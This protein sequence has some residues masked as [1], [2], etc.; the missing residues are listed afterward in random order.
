[1]STCNECEKK[2]LCCKCSKLLCQQNGSH[3]TSERN[4]TPGRPCSIMGHYKLVDDKVCCAD[5]YNQ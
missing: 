4:N 2:L 1:M 3:E 5:C